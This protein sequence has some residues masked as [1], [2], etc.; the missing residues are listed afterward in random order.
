M[1]QRVWRGW[2]TSQNAGAYEKL[3]REQIFPGIAAKGVRGYTGIKLLR[4]ALPSG[5]LEFMT[6][7][8]F[9]SLEA[10]RAFAGEDYERAYVPEAARRVLSRFDEVSAHY[11][12]V[13]QLAY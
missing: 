7:M 12:V 4:R 11:E 5:E 2:T 3:L 13:E 6:I 10:V 9:E 1:I 8:S